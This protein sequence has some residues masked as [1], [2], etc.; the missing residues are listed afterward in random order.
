MKEIGA[1]KIHLQATDVPCEESKDDGHHRSPPTRGWVAKL[2]QHD[3]V[4]SSQ[5]QHF[6]ES[7]CSHLSVARQMGE[8]VAACGNVAISHR[9]PHAQIRVVMN[10]T[11]VAFTGRPRKLCCSIRA[12]IIHDQNLV[13]PRMLTRKDST[14][15]NRID[16]ALLL[17]VGKQN[18]ADAWFAQRGATVTKLPAWECCVS[19]LSSF[20]KPNR[21][22]LR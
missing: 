22:G 2:G 8:V 7:L 9:C 16:N 20:F 1:G 12:S 13:I 3:G 21:E 6:G 10:D 14:V 17:I 11:H 4:F 5:R 19:V 15:R 18:E